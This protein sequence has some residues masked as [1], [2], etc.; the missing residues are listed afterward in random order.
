MIEQQLLSDVHALIQRWIDSMGHPGPVPGVFRITFTQDVRNRMA[1]DI[2][3]LVA[4][5]SAPNVMVHYPS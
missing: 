2:A 4:D 3:A 1:T 5:T